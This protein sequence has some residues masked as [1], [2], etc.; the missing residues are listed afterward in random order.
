[1]VGAMVLAA[2]RGAAPPASSG[3]RPPSGDGALKKDLALSL[4]FG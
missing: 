3:F 4:S 2:G 1:M